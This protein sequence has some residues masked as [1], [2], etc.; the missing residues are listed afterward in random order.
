MVSGIVSQMAWRPQRSTPGTMA[1]DAQYRPSSCLS[2]PNRK[3]EY[4]SSPRWSPKHRSCTLPNL[5]S[6][7]PL[8]H[9]RS[10]LHPHQTNSRH[11]NQVRRKQRRNFRFRLSQKHCSCTHHYTY[12]HSARKDHK[13]HPHQNHLS[14]SH[15]NHTPILDSC[16]QHYPLPRSCNYMPKALD[17]R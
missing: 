3:L 5:G 12:S 16:M 8:A 7:P 6:Q 17:N 15:C 14:K 13:P 11:C 10:H 1:A 9:R 4:H 2:N